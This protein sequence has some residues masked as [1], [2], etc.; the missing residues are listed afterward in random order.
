MKWLIALTS[1]L[2]AVSNL[3]L[4]QVYE[5]YIPGNLGRI[6]EIATPEG[7]LPEYRNLIGYDSSGMV[8]QANSTSTY[9]LFGNVP[10]NSEL[11]SG[12]NINNRFGAPTSHDCFEIRYGDSCHYW[13]STALAPD[14]LPFSVYNVGPKSA[15]NPSVT[16]G[17]KVCLQILDEDG[18]G[19]YTPGERLF[20]YGDLSLPLDS[21][22]NELGA[23]TV[24]PFKAS[25]RYIGNLRTGLPSVSYSS[26]TFNVGTQGTLPPSGTV[27]RLIAA[28]A[29]TG[30]PCVFISDTLSANTAKSYSFAFSYYSFETPVLSLI[31]PPSGMYLS[32]NNIVWNVAEE[33]KGQ[34]YPV[35][36]S[37]TNSAGTTYKPFIARVQP[38]YP[39]ITDVCSSIS[40]DSIYDAIL[41]LQN[42]G[43]RF[44]I[45][46]NRREVAEWIKN[47]FIQVGINDVRLDSFY[48]TLRWPFNTG[49]DYSQWHY[50][51]VATI[52]GTENPDSVFIM[53]GHHDNIL[54]PYSMGDPFIFTP[55]ADDNAS[56]TVA[57][58]EVARVFKKHNYQPKNTIKF[59]TFTAEEFGL[60][61]SADYAIKARNTNERIQMMLNNDMISNCQDSATDWRVD[62]NAYPNSD[63]ATETA[64]RAIEQHT[65]LQHSVINSASSGSDSYSFYTQGY[66]TVYFEE[67]RFSPFYHSQNDLV[68]NGNTRY[69]AQIVK[70][71][72]AMLMLENGTTI[73]TGI[74]QPSGNMAKEFQLMQNY[75]NPFNPS[76]TISYQLPKEERVSLKIYNILGQEVRTLVNQKQ[77][78][79]FHSVVWDGKDNLGHAATSGIYITRIQAGSFMKS[80][81]MTLIK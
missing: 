79:G 74:G 66:Q 49:S 11:N 61:G 33:Q 3:L 40:P 44:C 81:K 15:T 14:Q 12:F 59:I 2:L 76:T 77:A 68:S 19:L 22:Y 55:G 9:K 45:A 38:Y 46:P 57:A 47:K 64:V 39:E 78:A 26:T 36:L 69:M 8:K 7:V 28:S 16:G 75:P 60:Y 65:N 32:G 63:K 25:N 51:V 18:N 73:S 6:V 13:V 54:Y 50:N 10:S 23:A 30:K 52:P 53:G 37:A 48:K 71:N 42:F 58:I 29:D 56:G 35:V 24:Y 17:T 21:T 72:C 27:I 1:Y 70:A 31:N 20:L 67:Y 5:S 43:T 62:I 34:Q 80:M 4:A 41:S